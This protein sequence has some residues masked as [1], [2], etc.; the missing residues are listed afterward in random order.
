MILDLQR[1]FCD[2][3]IP[4]CAGISRARALLQFL[5]MHSIVDLVER[6]WPAS[7]VIRRIGR[8]RWEGLYRFAVIRDYKSIIQSD[9][10]LTLQSAAVLATAGDRFVGPWRERVE[11]AHRDPSFERF[12]REEYLGRYSGIQRGG[13]W[14]TFCQSPW[15]DE[16]GVE[17]I[18]FEQLEE[19]WPEICDR[20]DI[21]ALSGPP[22]S[23]VP[24]LPRT[25]SAPG[26]A[27]TWNDT[28]SRDVDA[29]FDGDRRVLES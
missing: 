14:R 27:P 13:F 26:P 28:L 2:I 21:R 1:G 6:H 11:R 29:Y 20:L 12:V 9:W 4:R 10:R 16:L 23:I 25:N 18:L 8:T 24:E 19:R 15:G 3:H 5:S 17:P 22:M 7:R